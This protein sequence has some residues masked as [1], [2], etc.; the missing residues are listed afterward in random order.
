MMDNYRSHIDLGVLSSTSLD[1]FTETHQVI[2]MFMV[3]Y[4]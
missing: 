1:D 4:L 2:L 3:L